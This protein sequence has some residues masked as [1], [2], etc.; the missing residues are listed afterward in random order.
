[1]QNKLSMNNQSGAKNIKKNVVHD[2]EIPSYNM[3]VGLYDSY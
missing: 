2:L 1:M 3:L